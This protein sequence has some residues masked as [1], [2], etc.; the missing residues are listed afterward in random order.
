V[1]VDARDLLWLSLDLVVAFD[2][3]DE[4]PLDLDVESLVILDCSSG[5]IGRSTGTDFDR[6]IMWD[7]GGDCR[8]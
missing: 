6:D 4:S 1:F 2:L 8:R 7:V 5:E 3:N